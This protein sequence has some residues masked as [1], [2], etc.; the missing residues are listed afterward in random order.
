MERQEELNAIEEGS[1]P[2]PWNVT[3]RATVTV[4][5]VVALFV[6]TTVVLTVF[7]CIF[8]WAG[9]A[10]ESKHGPVK[11]Q[12]SEEYQVSLFPEHWDTA[13]KRVAMAEEFLQTFNAYMSEFSSSPGALR[14]TSLTNVKK[15]TSL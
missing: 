15:Q 12:Y 7:V 6:A 11:L 10:P 8:L 13:K 14:S 9:L 5:A 1:H 3:N 4:F 2:E